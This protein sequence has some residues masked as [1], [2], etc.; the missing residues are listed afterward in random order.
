MPV[1]NEGHNTTRVQVWV[2]LR[3]LLDEH[4][5]ARIITEYT[6]NHDVGYSEDREL[7][8]VLYHEKQNTIELCF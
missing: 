3:T 1:L 8:A 5:D 2:R 6:C 4:P 7:A